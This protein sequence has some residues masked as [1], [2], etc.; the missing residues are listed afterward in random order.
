MIYLQHK[1]NKTLIASTTYPKRNAENYIELTKEEYD[2]LQA[3]AA[4][5]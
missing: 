2:A 5:E 3:E 4:I 1:E